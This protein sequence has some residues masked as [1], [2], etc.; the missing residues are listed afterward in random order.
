MNDIQ[1]ESVDRSKATQSL[2]C[3]TP[4]R[5][6]TKAG[7]VF[8]P[9]GKC[10]ACLKS[11]SNSMR[12]KIK[13]H[14]SHYKYTFFITLTYDIEHA[15]TYLVK[16]NES[17]SFVD[18]SGCKLYNALFVRKSFIDVDDHDT[19]HS[20]A[21]DC[22]YS[23]EKYVDPQSVSAW[24]V[25]QL[26]ND[27]IHEVMLTNMF[28][29]QLFFKRLRSYYYDLKN[30]KINYETFYRPNTDF[31][32]K[33]QIQR[34]YRAA[35]PFLASS[36]RIYA[37][38]TLGELY[39]SIGYNAFIGK[40]L[41]LSYY[42][43]SEYGGTTHR[44]HYHV[45]CFTNS[46][47]VA[48][49][50][51]MF[52]DRA[53]QC[54]IVDFQLSNGFSAQY[55]AGYV[56]SLSLLPA[57]L[58][59]GF[60]SPSATHSLFNLV[61]KE[62]QSLSSEVESLIRKEALEGHIAHIGNKFSVKRLSF[63]LLC[64]LYFRPTT[65]VLSSPTDF[66]RLFYSL[67]RFTTYFNRILEGS[68]DKSIE[69]LSPLFEKSFIPIKD[70]SIA[71]I[72]WLCKNLYINGSF[73]P[74]RYNEL[75]DY[76]RL[77]LEYCDLKPYLSSQKFIDYGLSYDAALCHVFFNRLARF[78]TSVKCV[79]RYRHVNSLPQYERLLRFSVDFWQN[80]YKTKLSSLYESLECVS[81]PYATM[82][83]YLSDMQYYHESESESESGDFELMFEDFS[84]FHRDVIYSQSMLYKPR[85]KHNPN[86]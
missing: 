4:I 21:D 44:P 47:F 5:L 10:N 51:A 45:L 67:Y 14:S 20:N 33:S 65:N 12:D 39:E 17:D 64:R 15:P 57:F 25:S 61:P 59:S 36:E 73:V 38:K 79:C 75:P 52:I 76:V 48:L 55:V 8:V 3:L 56:T 6:T 19:Y 28:D 74:S 53:W 62:Y 83:L 80:F 81:V 27:S 7:N 18:A 29:F 11:R 46:D 40:K 60:G 32:R 68:G 37:G 23:F 26:Y 82:I 2:R 78:I 49:T 16:Y 63:D 13:A 58:R 54:G 71:V 69:L 43:C 1:L 70:F 31:M 77:V 9:C 35:S 34:D 24:S 84:S 86:V 66:Y 30:K 41:D 42:A 85:L 22:F 50:L 72:S